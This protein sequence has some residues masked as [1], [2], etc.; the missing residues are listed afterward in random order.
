[1]TPTVL[2]LTPFTERF[3]QRLHQ[4]F[5]VVDASSWPDILTG[6]QGQEAQIWAVITSAVKG[7]PDEVIGRLPQLQ[8]I[9]VRGVGLDQVNVSLARAHGVSVASTTG[10]L[11][12]CVADL[13]FTLL[14]A[15]SR[16]LIPADRFVRSGQWQQQA[17]PL[18]ARV[19]RKRLGILGLGAIGRL[20]AQRAAGFDMDIAYYGRRPKADINYTYFDDVCAI[21]RWTDY[22]VVAVPGGPETDGLISSDVL[23]ALGPTGVLVNI[24]RGSVVDEEALLQA[25]R[26]R[27]IAG[28]GLDVYMNEPCAPQ[29]WQGLE[30]VVLTPHIGSATRETRQAMED[31]VLDNLIALQ[32][33]GRLLTP[34]E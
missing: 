26:T 18:A 8:A 31:L 27:T 16:Q 11:S 13:A 9:S 20:I 12:D 2:L 22:L 19:N 34:V 3:M 7:V 23:E 17:F 1:M 29:P 32:Q 24:A 33:Q 6:L 10:I 25:L 21:A 15:V 5:H 14:L 4:H 30:N 28:A